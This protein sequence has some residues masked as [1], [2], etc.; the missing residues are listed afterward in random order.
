MIVGGVQT[1]RFAV[2]RTGWKSAVWIVLRNQAARFAVFT[3]VFG[4]LRLVMC[5]NRLI[6]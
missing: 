1:L 3:L 4:C 5:K 2:A 6:R